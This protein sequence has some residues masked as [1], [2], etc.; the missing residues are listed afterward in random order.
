MLNK[1]KTLEGYKLDS[2]DGDI[3]KVKDIYFDDKFWTVRYLVVEAGDW[4]QPNMVLISPYAL[5]AC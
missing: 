5:I 4:I 3:G 1:A 2:I